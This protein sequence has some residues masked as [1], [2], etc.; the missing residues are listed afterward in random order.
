MTV[1]AE[2]LSEDVD[3]TWVL[4]F[5]IDA[6]PQPDRAVIG[7]VDLGGVHVGNPDPVNERAV[8]GDTPSL[9][10]AVLRALQLPPIRGVD[11]ALVTVVAGRGPGADGNVVDPQRDV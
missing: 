6:D 1:V 3:S 4:G 5:F 9:Q 2:A 8:P 11:P 7:E 10:F